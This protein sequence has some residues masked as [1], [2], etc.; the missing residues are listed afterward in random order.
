[1][2][3]TKTRASRN[4]DLATLLAV[5]ALAVSFKLSSIV[6]AAF[7]GVIALCVLARHDQRAAPRWTQSFVVAVVLSCLLLGSWLAR[8]VLLSGY[9]AYRT[10]L[11][12]G[13]E[14]RVP[15]EQAEAENAWI[16]HFARTYYSAAA[17]N[18]KP[19]VYTASL[20]GGWLRPWLR[21]LLTNASARWQVTIPVAVVVIAAVAA[22]GL[23]RH[24]PPSPSAHGWLPWTLLGPP[25]AGIAAWFLIA[26]RPV[27]GFALFWIL[28]ALV[29]A[30][31]LEY[32]LEAG[33]R[34]RGF[35]AI[36]TLIAVLPVLLQAADAAI[37][38]GTNPVAVLERALLVR[39]PPDAWSHP[40]PAP[41]LEVFVTASGLALYVPRNA[42]TCWTAP[43]PCTPHPSANLRLIDANRLGSGFI[44]SGPWNPT[45]YPNPDTRFLDS[46]K[47]YDARA[48]RNEHSS[49]RR[50]SPL[51]S[52]SDVS[53]VPRRMSRARPPCATVLICAVG[54]G[55]REG[56][57]V[58]PAEAT[59]LHFRA[60]LQNC[61]AVFVRATHDDDLFTEPTPA[62]V[63]ATQPLTAPATARIRGARGHAGRVCLRGAGDAG[64]RPVQ[65]ATG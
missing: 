18:D 3:P 15:V 35:V 55:R 27:F 53:R 48:R 4:A 41:D 52:T 49:P 11:S 31:L 38:R 36:A 20:A 26:P 46:W 50:K 56:E 40:T 29:V 39:P 23:R 42:N 13:L 12:P 10:V 22:L 45:R 17:Y 32:R 24:R 63:L 8:G 25:L 19:Y 6:F 5:L 30:L 57:A 16:R 47:E 21:S 2:R 9:P 61:P 1:M 62:R 43:L 65:H 44:S 33:D 7:A 14:W 59:D 37:R 64:E 51:H 34:G 54:R 60:R 58:P 28:A